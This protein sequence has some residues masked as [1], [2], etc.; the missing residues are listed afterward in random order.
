M[1][2]CHMGSNGVFLMVIVS[3]DGFSVFKCLIE[4]YIVLLM[5]ISV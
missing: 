1:L 4:G 3:Y 5:V 2:L